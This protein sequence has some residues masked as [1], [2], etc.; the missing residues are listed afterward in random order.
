[1]TVNE[2]KL[3]TTINRLGSCM[4]GQVN[5]IKFGGTLHSISAFYILHWDSKNATESALSHGFESSLGRIDMFLI[6][7]GTE[8][9]RLTGWGNTTLPAAA[10]S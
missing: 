1:M 3:L 6:H 10:A 7:Q 4:L 2:R 9:V 8:E 5:D